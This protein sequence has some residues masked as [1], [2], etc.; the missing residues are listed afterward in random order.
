MMPRKIASLGKLRKCFE[1]LN[2]WSFW[3]H[4]K[5]N[6]VIFGKKLELSVKRWRNFLSYLKGLKKS[7]NSLKRN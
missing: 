6:E 4:L 5:E 2:G 7:R 1:S 3:M